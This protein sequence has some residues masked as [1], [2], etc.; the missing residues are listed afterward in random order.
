MS[1]IPNTT[2]IPHIIIREWM[3]RL[4]DVELR[5]LIVVVDQT[6]GWIED[7]E[8]GRRKDR[9]W[10]SRGQL[11]E[12][13]GR[14]AKHVSRAVK[15]LVEAHHLVEAIDGK[16]RLLN[17]ADK[18]KA[19]FGKIFYRLTLHE[20]APSLFDKPHSRAVSY[21]ESKGLT[22]DIRGTK[23]PSTKGL[24]TKETHLQKE[25]QIHAVASATAP[26][27]KKK[28]HAAFVEFWYEMVQKTRGI[29]PVITAADGKNLKRVLEVGVPEPLLEQIALFFLEDFSFRK[30]SPT[31]RT[32]CSGGILNGLLNRTKNDP[33]FHRKLNGYVTRYL[34]ALPRE[35]FDTRSTPMPLPVEVRTY[36]LMEMQAGIQQLAARF[37]VKREP[38]QV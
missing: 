15:S 19:K 26:D 8:T 25:I 36:G 7:E 38:A 27:P 32:L 3:P 23:S 30:F 9:D 16:G 29:R 6:L 34:R 14:S 33:E 37:A 35:N 12:K 18:R 1:M 31:I 17:T 22:G 5:V 2:Q 4:S 13:T 20:P 21:R 11:M 10:I 28:D 24:T